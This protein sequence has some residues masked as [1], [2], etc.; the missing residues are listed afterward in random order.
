MN[1]RAMRLRARWPTKFD[2]VPP[3][4]V[5]RSLIM[6]TCSPKHWA[7]W[8]ALSELSAALSPQRSR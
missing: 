6:R 1:K 8:R 3:L 2:A 7:G 4:R 5:R